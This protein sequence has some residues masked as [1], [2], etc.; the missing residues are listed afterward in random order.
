MV[1]SQYRMP[2]APLAV[3]AGGAISLMGHCL[4]TS[5]EDSSRHNHTGGETQN[6]T[7]WNTT[8]QDY[9]Q[10][11]STDPCASATHRQ[12]VRENKRGSATQRQ[13][14]R[15][16]IVI[17]YFFSITFFWE[18]QTSS[19][20]HFDRQ[21]V[22]QKNGGPRRIATGSAKILGFLLFLITSFFS[23]PP[24]QSGRLCVCNR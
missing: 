18:T 7:L 13:E 12:G 17:L 15:E 22:R 4:K 2:P 21:G 1:A 20:F 19:H 3:C 10:L 16:K 24:L 14:V 6:D 23:S 11:G 8:A 5:E 9:N